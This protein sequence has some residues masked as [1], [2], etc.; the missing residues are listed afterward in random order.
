MENARKYRQEFKDK[1]DEYHR[2][3]SIQNKDKII[4]KNQKYRE[5]NK[6]KIRE[7]SR[8]Y[9]LQNKDKRNEYIREYKQKNKDKIRKY[10]HKAWLRLRELN[11]ELT[12]ET[13]QLWGVSQK[14][15][16][17]VATGYNYNGSHHSHHILPVRVYPEF[18][19]ED[20]NGA[21]IPDDWHLD[22]HRQYNPRDNPDPSFDWS[23]VLFDFIDFKI[24]E[25]NHDLT[26]L[27]QWGVV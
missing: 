27:E 16:E 2:R 14:V 12:S 22:F 13:R 17:A 25:S 11:P 23:G 21:V 8:R 20:W 24:R 7:Y 15:S 18:A 10:K 4:Q 1:W 6:D 3:Y 9:Y 19:L 26:T 5:Q